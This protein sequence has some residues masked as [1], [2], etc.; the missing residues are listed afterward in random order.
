[1][2]FNGAEGATAE[3]RECVCKRFST[4]K[5]YC[6]SACVRVYTGAVMFFFGLMVLSERKFSL[7][8]EE[9]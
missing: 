2:W 5:N 4:V 8:A 3:I 9:D 6:V 7:S 1:M